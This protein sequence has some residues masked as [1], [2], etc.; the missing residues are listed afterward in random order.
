[1]VKPVIRAS[2]VLLQ[3][4]W[5]CHALVSTHLSGKGR[6]NPTRTLLS[7]KVP[8]HETDVVVVGSGLAGLC[9]GALLAHN[10]VRVSILESHDSVGGAIHTWERGGFHFES[11]PSLYS[12]FSQDRSPNPLRGIFDIVGESPEWLTYDRWGTV[13]PEGRFAA[14]L[15][16]IHHLSRISCLRLFD[17]SMSST[18]LTVYQMKCRYSAR[19]CHPRPR[20]V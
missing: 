12:G 5:C 11:G 17:N 20:G 4:A 16:L 6:L 8:N 7:S 9:C 1:M 18:S 15:G 3:L 2:S 19:C 14:K 10:G 13:I